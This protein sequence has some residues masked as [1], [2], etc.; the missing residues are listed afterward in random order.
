MVE[1]EG[2]AESGLASEENSGS[3]KV[4]FSCDENAFE[5]AS[6]TERPKKDEVI[7]VFSCCNSAT[8]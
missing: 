6:K 2:E 4:L 8:N 7:E 5:C 1:L 3:S